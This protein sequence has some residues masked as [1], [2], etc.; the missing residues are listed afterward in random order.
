LQL[1]WQQREVT[2]PCL[3]VGT[4]QGWLLLRDVVLK[5]AGRKMAQLLALQL[6]L[7]A[8]GGWLLLQ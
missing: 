3:V 6:L 7:A 8:Q 2:P 5:V 1:G 4:G